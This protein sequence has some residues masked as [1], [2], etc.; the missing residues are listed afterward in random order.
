MFC[1]AFVFQSG[2][3]PVLVFLAA[4][5]SLVFPLQSVSIHHFLGSHVEILFRLFWLRTKSIGKQKY[6]YHFSLY[7]YTYIFKKTSREISLKISLPVRD[8]G[9]MTVLK[10]WQNYKCVFLASPVC[11]LW[12]QR[13]WL[14]SLC[15]CVAGSKT[16]PSSM[17]GTCC[18]ACWGRAASVR[19][20]RSVWGG[21]DML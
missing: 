9:Q 12:C 6:S 7:I 15:L 17:S 16:T 1:G 11:C 14:A 10:S 19:C 20:T 18:Y 21:A 4:R 5:V 3:C 8:S 13:G 2:I